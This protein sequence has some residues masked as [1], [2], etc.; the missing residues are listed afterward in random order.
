M[1]AFR[2][3]C[4]AHRPACLRRLLTVPLIFVLTLGLLTP[5]AFAQKYRLAAGVRLGRPDVGLTITQRLLEHTTLEAIGSAAANDLTLTLLARQHTGLLG[6]ALNLYAGLGPHI[7]DTQGQGTFYG[8]TA[9]VGVEWKLPIFPLVIA[10]DWQP[11]LSANR[12]ERFHNS[13]AFSLRYVVLKEKKEGFFRRLFG[14][15]KEKETNK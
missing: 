6:H 1:I 2:A 7:G 8:G 12:P 10:Y 9:V 13:T 4:G 5:N 3:R 14:K 11:S 15:K